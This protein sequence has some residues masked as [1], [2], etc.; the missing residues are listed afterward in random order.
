MSNLIRVILIRVSH[1]N[2][3][4]PLCWCSSAAQCILRIHIACI[5][6]MALLSLRSGWR[7]ASSSS[8]P[9]VQ[10]GLRAFASAPT[11]QQVSQRKTTMST[12]VVLSRHRCARLVAPIVATSIHVI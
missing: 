12:H 8:R 3:T 7:L 11:E 6:N 4:D 10:A 9:F 5:S 2:E 1:A